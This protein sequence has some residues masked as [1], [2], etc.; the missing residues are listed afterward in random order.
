VLPGRHLDV[1]DTLLDMVKTY[2]R[3]AAEADEPLKAFMCVIPKVRAHGK[4]DTAEKPD[5]AVVSWIVG[6]YCIIGVPKQRP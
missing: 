3:R 6:S 2:A 5:L 4:A 1:P